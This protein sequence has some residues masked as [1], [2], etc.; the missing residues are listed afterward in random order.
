MIT[1]FTCPRP[2]E[3]HTGV[4]QRNARLSWAAL[5][6]GSRYPFVPVGEDVPVESDAYGTPLVSSVFEQGERAYHTPLLAYINADII[7]LADFWPAVGAVACACPGSFLMVGQRWDIDITA[8]LDFS[9][10]W[11]DS[12]RVNIAQR[13]R[14]HQPAGM[15]YFIYRRGSLGD[16]PPFSLGRQRWDNWL[17]WDALERGVPV[18]DA[19]AALT[20]V[21][22]N[23]D[24]SH[25][26]SHGEH[27]RRGNSILARLSGARLCTTLDATY[28]LTSEGLIKRDVAQYHGAV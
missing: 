3:G 18:I 15:D 6:F 25:H 22:Q 20:A 28:A 21:H 14:L 11:Q 12:L 8:P 2:H 26:G 19:T 23:H 17:V 13:G 27:Q 9:D 10:G 5:G 1:L 7:L 24:Y 16:I 4:I